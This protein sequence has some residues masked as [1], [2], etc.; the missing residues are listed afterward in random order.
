[1]ELDEKGLATRR[2][3][4]GDTYA[5]SAL[6]KATLFTAPLQELVTRRVALAHI[7][8]REPRFW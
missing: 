1:M 8:R 6:A 7:C 3:V 5:D 4:L 2:P